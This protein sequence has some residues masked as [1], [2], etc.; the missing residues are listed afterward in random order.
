MGAVLNIRDN[1]T[2]SKAMDEKIQ[3]LR[4]L[5]DSVH[6][7][8]ILA[9]EVKEGSAEAWMARKGTWISLLV[10]GHADIAYLYYKD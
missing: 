8:P 5:P 4:L 2:W 3:R 6:F 10:E 9:F 7:R 1:P